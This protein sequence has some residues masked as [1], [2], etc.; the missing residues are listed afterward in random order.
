MDN[1]DMIKSPEPKL[2]K[3]TNL[4][5]LMQVQASYNL[6]LGQ[7]NQEIDDFSTSLNPNHLY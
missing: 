3:P 6:V 1:I 5:S 4:Q 2:Q 7:I